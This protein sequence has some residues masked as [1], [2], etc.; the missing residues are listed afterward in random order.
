[1][2]TDRRRSDS[3]MM[4]FLDS[5][6]EYV[7]AEYSATRLCRWIILWALLMVGALAMLHLGA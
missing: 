3:E 4:A 1:M 5:Y 6:G 2:S 7:K